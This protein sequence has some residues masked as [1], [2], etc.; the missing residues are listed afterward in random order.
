MDYFLCIAPTDKQRLKHS[1]IQMFCNLQDNLI[2]FQH[3]ERCRSSTHRPLCVEELPDAVPQLVEEHGVEGGAELQPQQVLHIGAHVEAH[4]VVATHQQGQ[5]PVHEAADGRLAGGRRGAGGDGDHGVVD[6]AGAHRDHGVFALAHGAHGGAVGGRAGGAALLEAHATQSTQETCHVDPLLLWGGHR[7]TLNCR[8]TTSWW[9]LLR[10][11]Y[12]TK[13][14]C[15]K[16]CLK[17]RC[18][19]GFMD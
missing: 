3:S 2:S 13:C 11:H 16:K 4:P 5:Q 18:L 10:R 14:L 1:P 19:H 17:T 8:S 12:S 6:V 7:E 9:L 15:V